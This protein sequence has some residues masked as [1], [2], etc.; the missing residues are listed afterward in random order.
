MASANHQHPNADFPNRP[1]SLR[2]PHVRAI[3]SPHAP[4]FWPESQPPLPTSRPTAKNSDEQPQIAANLHHHRIPSCRRPAEGTATRYESIRT[5][6]GLEIAAHNAS[7]CMSLCR[8]RPR[9]CDFIANLHPLL[10]DEP[11]PSTPREPAASSSPDT[12]PLRDRSDRACTRLLPVC[13]RMPSTPSS[14][15][16]PPRGPALSRTLRQ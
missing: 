16:T 13:D 10:R 14:K 12:L 11:W 7:H 3:P 2:E 5:A 1:I 4:N 8:L 9:C 15:A 6:I